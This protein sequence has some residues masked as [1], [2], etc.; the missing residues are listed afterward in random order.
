MATYLFFRRPAC[1]GAELARDDV[2]IFNIK[3][4]GRPLSRAS[5]APTV[6]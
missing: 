3:V 2:G 5:S 1:A 4:T 6:L